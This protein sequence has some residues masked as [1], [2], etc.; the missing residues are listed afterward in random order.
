[1]EPSAAR[2]WNGSWIEMKKEGR[3]VM[4]KLILASASPRR[5]ELLEQAGLCF[6]VEAADVDENI[7]NTEPSS[8]VMELSRRKAQAVADRLFPQEEGE[9]VGLTEGKKWS[10]STDQWKQRK[11][12][13][14]SGTALGMKQTF[15]ANQWKQRKAETET[16]IVYGAKR[17]A[18]TETGNA[19]GA[20]RK[21]ETETG[22]AYGA[23][24]KAETGNANDTNWKTETENG[25]VIGAKGKTLEDIGPEIVLGADTIVVL[26][27]K[28]LGKPKNKEDAV[29]MLTELSGREHEV[30]T[31][32]TLLGRQTAKTFYECTKVIMYDNSEEMIRA[33][34]DTGEPLDKAGAYGIQGRG[35]LLVKEIRGDYN[36]VVGLPVARVARELAGYFT[37]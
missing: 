31:G 20:G 36:N 19:Y 9:R 13:S 25:D 21:A 37:K 28:I 4:T 30:Y 14:L 16:G 23:G 34:V 24:R 1:M 17:K 7:E 33:Y 12:E 26:D 10:F 27:G 18:E 8:Y 32:V 35:T 22:N 29:R 6:V 2:K 15:T 11:E 5:K 3:M